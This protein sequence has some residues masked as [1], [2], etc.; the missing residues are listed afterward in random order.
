MKK[1][2]LLFIGMLS[3]ANI[4]AQNINDALR[5][6]TENLSGTARFRSMSG[7]FG[8]LGGDF[9]AVAIN[10]AG[11]AVFLNSEVTFSLGNADNINDSRFFGSLASESNNTFDLNQLGGVFVFNNLNDTADW[12]KFSIGFNYENINDFNNEIFVA[13][14]NPNNSIDQYFLNFAQGVPLDLINLRTDETISELYQFLGENEDETV[15]KAFLGYQAFILEPVDD[16]DPDNTAY[17]SNAAYNTVDQQ[18]F[19]T[20]TGANRKFSINFATQY[21]DNLYLGLNINSHVVD[22]DKRIVLSEIGFDTASTITEITY[23]DRLLTTGEGISF[24]FGAIA[25]TNNGLRLGFSY[26]S[27]TWYRLQ[28]ET[29]ESLTAF[30]LEGTEEIRENIN[31]RVINIFE[32]YKIQ[33]PGKLTGSFAYLF[34]KQ[35]LISFDYSYK[36]YSDAT[37]RPESDPSFSQENNFISNTLKAAS[38]YR[39]GAEWRFEQFSFRGGYRLEESPYED[40]RIMDD[41]DGYSFGMGFNFG[42]VTLD[43]AF[44]R[45]NRRQNKQLFPVGLTDTALIDA[46]NTNVTA[47]LSLKL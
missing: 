45:S 29:Q 31:P 6:S 19:E 8:A 42:S 41:L 14:F 23:R 3:M 27:P 25:K 36:D 2:I 46:E 17:T 20:T 24:Q 13:G 40:I 22:F 28:D 33:T 26:Q 44:D 21:K 9:S 34:G 5:Y 15:Q 18:Y 38:T 47:T 4:H 7:A 32:D 12:R 43:L 39:I 30:R 11:G 16:A 35:G 37:I 1:L 10:P